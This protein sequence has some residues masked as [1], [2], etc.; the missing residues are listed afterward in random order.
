MLERNW[1]GLRNKLALDGVLHPK[2]AE[3]LW[4]KSM[5]SG[6][7]PSSKAVFEGLTSVLVKLGVALPVGRT[8]RLPSGFHASPKMLVIMRLPEAC[9]GN[10][11]LLFDNLSAETQPGD[12]EVT[13]KWRFEKGGPPDGLVERV[14]AACHVLGK[15]E[16]GSCWR[17]GAVFRKQLEL[18]VAGGV[19]WITIALG[20]TSSDDSRREFVARVFGSLEYER[21]WEAIRYVASAVATFAKEWP[22]LEWE[23]WAECAAHR[24]QHAH[25]ASSA[26][27]RRVLLLCF[28]TTARSDLRDTSFACNGARV[29][30]ALKSCCRKSSVLRDA[31]SQVVAGDPLIAEAMPGATRGGCDGLSDKGGVLGLVLERLGNFIDIEKESAME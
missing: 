8:S 15:L 23:G 27:V 4:N 6:G 24:Q 25:L 11:Q 16:K 22:G 21:V 20:T 14:I 29:P 26:H 5:G 9:N 2:F 17:H 28:E 3:Y 12:R 1:L 18:R 30:P 13:L 19:P 7:L 31:L 10:Q